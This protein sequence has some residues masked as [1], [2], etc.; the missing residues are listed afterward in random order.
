[1]SGVSNRSPLIYL[2]SLGNLNLL[3]QL[4]GHIFVPQAVHNEVVVARRGKPGAEAVAAAR[5][6]WLIVERVRDRQ[7]V[8]MHTKSHGLD[9][10]EAEAIVL[11][12]E[13]RQSYSSMTILR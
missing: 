9:V 11:A 12:Q 6:R 2:A 1:V 7:R 3:P 10:G 4:F 5:W 8:E 13:L